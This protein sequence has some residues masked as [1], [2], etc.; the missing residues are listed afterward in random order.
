MWGKELWSTLNCVI[1]EFMKKLESLTGLLI[2]D[3]QRV[4]KKT[5]LSYFNVIALLE[6]SLTCYENWREIWM[7]LPD[8]QAKIRNKTFGIR[9]RNANNS[10]DNFCKNLENLF[11]IISLTIFYTLHSHTILPST[12]QPVY[13]LS[14]LL[15][16][17]FGRIRPSSGVT[18][19]VPL[20][21]VCNFT[22][23]M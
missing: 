19:I 4:W 2:D 11:L 10:T 22:H 13:Y 1:I 6:D 16:T 23:H 20:C 5:F 15:A 18:K 7:R 9:N 3:L 21:S 12:S 17:C 14:L 8:F